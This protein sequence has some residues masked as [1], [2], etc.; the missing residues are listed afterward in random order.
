MKPMILALFVVVAAGFA[1]GGCGQK[2]ALYLPGHNP[3]PPKPL[4]EPADQNAQQSPDQ[5][6][7]G[8]SDASVSS[9]SDSASDGAAR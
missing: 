6:H 1:L 4:L 7:G 8:A 2:G 5:D 9:S 3:N